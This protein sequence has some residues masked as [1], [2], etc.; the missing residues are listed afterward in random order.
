MQAIERINL[1]KPDTHCFDDDTKSDVWSYSRELVISTVLAHIDK[2]EAEVERLRKDAERYR[3][4]KSAKR[5]NGRI[6]KQEK[7]MEDQ[8]PTAIEACMAC[9]SDDAA[10][11]HSV[12]P[13][14]EVADNML[15]AETLMGDMAR[16]LEEVRRNF[17]RED[18]LPDGLLGRI[19]AVL[20]AV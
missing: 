4:L 10:T 12:N 8:E 15:R 7:Y 14:D 17:T 11:L 18:D 1:P 9:L 2:L 5:P 6:V 19:D 16:L 20:D 13:E 3:W